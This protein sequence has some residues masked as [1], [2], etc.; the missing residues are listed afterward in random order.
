VSLASYWQAVSALLR[1][2]H[3][4]RMLQQQAA[5][6]MSSFWLHRQTTQQQVK[7]QHQQV[8]NSVAPNHLV[9]SAPVTFT[10]ISV[11][12]TSFVLLVFGLASHKLWQCPNNLRNTGVS[13]HLSQSA[14]PVRSSCQ[15]VH[16]F[17][18]ALFW[19]CT[20]QR[21]GKPSL[22]PQQRLHQSCGCVSRWSSPPLCVCTHYSRH[23]C[24]A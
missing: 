18:P 5:A 3:K 9:T 1:A 11:A 12:A 21:T 6:A 8:S 2:G 19:C 20:P 23:Q 13:V 24:A 15:P 4:P 17:C 14:E 22:H 10:S 7:P 16:P